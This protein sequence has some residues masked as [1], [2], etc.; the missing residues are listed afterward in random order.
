[1][2]ATRTD[3]LVKPTLD[4]P[5]GGG[6]QFVALLSQGLDFVQ[7]RTIRHFFNSKIRADF[8][9]ERK[10]ERK[11]RCYSSNLKWWW[12]S[13]GHFWSVSSRLANEAKRGRSN[14]THD[15]DVS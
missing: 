10:K 11:K 6:T 15:L 13:F 9:K 12:W 2:A 8:K 5:E 14:E 7:M 4:L 3:R 1:L